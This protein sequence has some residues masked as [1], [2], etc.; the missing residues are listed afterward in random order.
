MA[1]HRQPRRFRSCANFRERMQALLPCICSPLLVR[2]M[3]ALLLTLCFGPCGAGLASGAI[4]TWFKASRAGRLKRSKFSSGRWI[5]FRCIRP[6]A[7]ATTS[8]CL[9][10]PCLLRAACRAR[11]QQWLPIRSNLPATPM[12]TSLRTCRAAMLRWMR[13]TARGLAGNAPTN[14]GSGAYGGLTT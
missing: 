4:V 10:L 11:L 3:A 12:C 13:L 8:R 2:R 6:R 7:T 1:M 9:L 5:C 14:L